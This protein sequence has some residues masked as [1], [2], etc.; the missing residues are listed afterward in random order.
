VSDTQRSERETDSSPEETNGTAQATAQAH[1]EVL[2]AENRR[3]RREAVR[4]RQ[5]SHRRTAL[6]LAVIGLVGVVSATLFPSLQTVLLV[7]GAI[8]LFGAVLTYYLTPE[9]FVAADV[10]DRVAAAMD[11]SLQRLATQLGLTDQ[12][13]IVPTS[14]PDA[15][16]LYVP[17]EEIRDLSEATFPTVE[18][19]ESPF[20]TDSE[21]ALGLAIVPAGAN[22]FGAFSEQ[23][24]SERVSTVPERL[25]TLGE[26]LREQFELVDAVE[27][28]S[29]TDGEAT[30]RLIEPV[31]ADGSWF[32]DPLA[33]FLGVGLT[34]HLDTPVSV[35]VRT[36]DPDRIIQ[37]RWESTES[38]E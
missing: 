29:T 26:A 8:G 9:R 7:L 17:I 20:V 12:R 32:E 5:T 23:G 31:Y 25:E 37:F 33:S 30:V 18:A 3:L 22:L 2:Q 1:L 21:G 14:G 24:P 19:L 36:D 28:E 10:G 4:A 38:S 6:G 27:I 11:E 34:T 13:I 16:T 35:T 15:A